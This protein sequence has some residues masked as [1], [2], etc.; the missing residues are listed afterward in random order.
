MPKCPLCGTDEVF[1]CPCCKELYCRECTEA[2]VMGCVH[3][4]RIREVTNPDWIIVDEATEIPKEVWDRLQLHL[5]HPDLP[6][7]ARGRFIYGIR[8]LD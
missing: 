5:E 2:T 6:E 1:S 3:K 8:R 4:K 7:R